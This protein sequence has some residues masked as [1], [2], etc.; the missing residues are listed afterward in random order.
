MA[1][2]AELK[3]LITNNKGGIWYVYFRNEIG[4]ASVYE[5]W[6]STKAGPS[7]FTIPPDHTPQTRFWLEDKKRGTKEYFDYFEQLAKH[8]DELQGE[9][10]P[11]SLTIGQLSWALKVEQL[12]AVL[13]AMAS[14]LGVV[15]YLGAKVGPHWFGL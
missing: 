1:T 5:I 12:W 14:A 3:K 2:E 9:I 15:F 6:T 8:L 10:E 4:T 11:G 7:D 13:G